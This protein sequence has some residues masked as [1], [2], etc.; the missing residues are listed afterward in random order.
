MRAQAEATGK[1]IGTLVLEA[2][3]PRL[4]LAQLSIKEILA[5]VHD[6]LRQSGLTDGEL[7][8]LLKDSLQDTRSIRH[9]A[10]SLST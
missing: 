4:S 5:P 7:D 10:P 3:V 8:A 1:D 9:S 6:D 2:V